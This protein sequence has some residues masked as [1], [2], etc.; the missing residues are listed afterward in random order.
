MNKC[1]DDAIKEFIRGTRARLPMID[2][3]W[4]VPQEIIDEAIKPF[5]RK[6]IEDEHRK[7]D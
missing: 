7:A 6:G 3:N 1:D 5:I 4:L 2:D